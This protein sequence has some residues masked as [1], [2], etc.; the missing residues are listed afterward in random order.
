MGRSLGQSSRG[1][2]LPLPRLGLRQV[3]LGRAVPLECREVSGR[4]ELDVSKLGRECSHCTG[5]RQWLCVYTE[6]WRR[7][8]AL[9]SYFVGVGGRANGREGVSLCEHC[10]LG[11]CSQISN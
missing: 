10:L 11:T 3:W 1:G 8:M 5:S 6:G 2:C 4:R 7:E 9:S